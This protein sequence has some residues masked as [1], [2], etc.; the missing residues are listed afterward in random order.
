MPTHLTYA[1]IIE[2]L[3]HLY[4]RTSGLSISAAADSNDLS[5]WSKPPGMSPKE[6]GEL[7]EQACALMA[8]QKRIATAKPY[9]ETLP[10]DLVAIPRRKPFPLFKLQVRCCAYHQNSIYHL[11]LR[12]NSGRDPFQKGDFD[13]MVAL[14]IPAAAWYIIPFRAL[15]RTVFSAL[16]PAETRKSKFGPLDRYRNRW[17]LLQ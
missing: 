5:A 4:A 9:G 3:R 2:L 1:H 6:L 16:H 14:L 8:A 11:H 12:K 7:A 10:F 13:F 15:P 17:D